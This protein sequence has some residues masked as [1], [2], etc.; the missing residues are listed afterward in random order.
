MGILDNKSRVFDVLLTQQGRQ[1]VVDGKMRIEYVTFTD[2]GT[3]YKADIA[4]GSADA[5]TRLY[6]ECCNLP[7]DMITFEANDA[8]RLNSFKNLGGI[9]VRDGRI[10]SSSITAA[11]GSIVTGSNE[12]LTVLTGS[13]FASTA[14]SLLAS[15]IDNFRQLRILGTQG[16]LLDSEK[17]EMSHN[18]VTFSITDD[19]PIP[20]NMREY[21]HLSRLEGLFSDPRLSR[22]IN[23]KY[24]PP[25]N[26]NVDRTIDTTDPVAIPDELKIAHFK[27]WGLVD[28]LDIDDVVVEL[29]YYEQ[30]GYMREVKFDPTSRNN[31]IVG[32]FFELTNNELKKLDII[33]FGRHPWQDDDDRVKWLH[34]FFVGKVM[35]DDNGDDTFIHIFTLVFK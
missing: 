30:T 25:V 6:L 2:D 9:E 19:R 4:S 3:F 5:T 32:Q 16:K 15:S 18:Q 1:Q 31:T 28:P 23:Y 11:S 29:A 20:S 35:T 10:V 34:V 24:L 14:G 22:A 8:G 17:F 26:K 27:P 13:V 12:N 7:Q 33:D 21:N